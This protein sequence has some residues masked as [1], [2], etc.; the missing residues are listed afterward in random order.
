MKSLLASITTL[1]L[2]LVLSCNAW[3]AQTYGIEMDLSLDTSQYADGDVL[4]A[5]QKIA[6]ASPRSSKY[7][8]LHSITLL[9]KDYQ[10][11]ALDICLLDA[12]KSIGTE[13]NQVSVTDS[14][15][16]HILGCI[17]VAAGDYVDLINAKLVT[18]TNLGFVVQEASTSGDM[19][20]ALISRGTGTYSASGIHLRLGF[21]LSGP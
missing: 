13:N 18:K 15:A 8:A 10:G 3:A 11:A 5:T 14:D 9:D 1:V 17:E 19:Y 12:N 4:A 6:L 20:L 2:P 16:E 21:I 7:E